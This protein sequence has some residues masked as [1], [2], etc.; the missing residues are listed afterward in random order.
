MT[1]LIGRLLNSSG[2]PEQRIITLVPY[3]G[4]GEIIIRLDKDGG[5]QQQI[6][7]G[8]YTLW[9]GHK[10]KIVTIADVRYTKIND[11]VRGAL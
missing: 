5:I 7:P 8:E 1:I 11:L 2:E 4:G 3:N 6:A 9:L 10:P